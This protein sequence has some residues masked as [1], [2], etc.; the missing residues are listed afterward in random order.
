[1]TCRDRSEMFLDVFTLTSERHELDR[2]RNSKADRRIKFVSSYCSKNSEFDRNRGSKADRRSNSLFKQLIARLI[3]YQAKNLI[4]CDMWIWSNFI[5]KHWLIET[6]KS[7]SSVRF[8]LRS[9]LIVYWSVRPLISVDISTVMI[10]SKSVYCMNV[11]YWL[12]EY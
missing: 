6:Q 3:W 4:K 1:M 12:N 11:V 8:V 10:R 5:T 2:N 9:S 7:R